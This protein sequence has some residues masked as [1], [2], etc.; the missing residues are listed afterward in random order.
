MIAM[1]RSRIGTNSGTPT[2]HEPSGSRVPTGT[3]VLGSTHTGS[4]KRLTKSGTACAKISC[5]SAMDEELSIMKTRSIF[6]G[7]PAS[8][9]GAAAPSGR[10][11]LMMRLPP[12]P[13]EPPSQL[14]PPPLPVLPLLPEP[15]V[16]DVPLAEEGGDFCG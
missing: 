16:V 1:W 14:A 5:L 13:T 6:Q 3:N 12:A 8:P 11:G 9:Q 7:V 2:A 4:R 15:A 10:V